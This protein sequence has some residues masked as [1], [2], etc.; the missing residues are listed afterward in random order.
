METAALGSLV[1]RVVWLNERL[2]YNPEVVV[3]DIV[4][5]RVPLD[6]PV[7]RAN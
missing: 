5:P 4:V 1:G 6:K 3:T 2:P 7:E